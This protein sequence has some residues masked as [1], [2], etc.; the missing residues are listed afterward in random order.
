MKFTATLEKIEFKEERGLRFVVGTFTNAPF[1][2]EVPL[3]VDQLDP[4]RV[5]RTYEFVLSWAQENP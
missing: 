2:A 5:G 4:L 1:Y 3:G